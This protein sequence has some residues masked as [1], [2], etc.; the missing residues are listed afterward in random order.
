VDIDEGL[1]RVGG[2]KKLYLKLLNDFAGNY[3]SFMPNIRKAI[4]EQK[5][6]EARRLTHTLKGVSGNLSAKDLF[7]LSALLEK[8]LFMTPPQDFEPLL[9]QLDSALCSVITSVETVHEEPV[10]LTSEQDAILAED[11]EPILREAAQLVWADD[12]DAGKA[13]TK[14]K[15]AFGR[16]FTAEVEEIE[17]SVDGFDFEAAKVPIRKIA[18]ELNIRLDGIDNE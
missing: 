5:M 10:E 14:L 3:K 4:S 7:S 11:F 15:Q 9:D 8:A 18:T 2:N 6:D 13:I 17:Q 16:S 1:S 12:I